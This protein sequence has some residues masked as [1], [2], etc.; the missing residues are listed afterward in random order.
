MALTLQS[1]TM[2]NFS[3]YYIHLRY[4]ASA[5]VAIWGFYSLY[6]G[7]ANAA[8]ILF[9]MALIGMSAT[10]FMHLKISKNGPK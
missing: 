7:N 3:I 8:K 4:L 5:I 6:T 2:K 9:F 10:V 1:L